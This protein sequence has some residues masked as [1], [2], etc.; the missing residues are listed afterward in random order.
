[1]INKAISDPAGCSAD[2]RSL[3]DTLD[4]LG[5]KWTLRIIHYLLLRKEETNTFRKMEK[6]ISGISAKMLSKELK[7]LEA[8]KLV[9]REEMPTKPATVQYSITCY[10][11]AAQPVIEAML[12]WGSQHRKLILHTGN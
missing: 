11:Q 8:N 5:G 12:Q 1:M 9:S 7:L 3:T 10:G 2:I 4:I 6:D